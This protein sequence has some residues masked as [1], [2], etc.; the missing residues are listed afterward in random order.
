MAEISY[1]CDV[2]QGFNFQKDVQTVIGH[3]NSLKISDKDDLKADLNI[4][5]PENVS[6]LVKVFGIASNIYWAGGYADPVQLSCQVSTENKNVLATLQHKS[7]A[8]T[9][10]ELVFTIYDYDPKEKKYF[11]CFHTNEAKLKGL[12]HKAG[13][14][15]EMNISM[16][17]SMEIVSPRNYTFALGTM[18]QDVDQQIHL[19][20]SLS[21]KFVMKWGVE[22]GG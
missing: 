21:G 17:Q 3:I 1:S 10:V 4:T 11:K 7:M 12:I 14:E 15:L 8:N 6:E 2:A 19:A 9:E 16:D 13:G 18:P 5:D 22:V 20:V